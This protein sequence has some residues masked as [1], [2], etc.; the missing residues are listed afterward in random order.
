[1]FGVEINHV[2]DEEEPPGLPAITLGD[3]IARRSELKQ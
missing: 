1:M 3:E 2:K